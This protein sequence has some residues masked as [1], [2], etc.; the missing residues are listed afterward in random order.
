MIAKSTVSSFN[1]TNLPLVKGFLQNVSK[2]YYK[3]QQKCVT[4][5]GSFFIRK[6]AAGS[7]K[8]GRYYKM[9]RFYY[10]T[11]QVLQNTSV[12]TK[13]GTAA[14]SKTMKLYEEI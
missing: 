6:Y 9:R 2:F 13:R 4:K 10:K 11:R 14:S 12:I 7:T 3:M 1:L 8:R 5:L